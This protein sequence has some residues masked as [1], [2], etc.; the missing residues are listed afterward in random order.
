MYEFEFETEAMP[1]SQEFEFEYEGEELMRHV[2]RIPQHVSMARIGQLAARAALSA[3]PRFQ[4]LQNEYEF[5]FEDEFEGEF[6]FE[7]ELNPIRRVYP[8]ALME[9]MGHAAA[10]TESEAEAEAFVGALV[11]MAARLAAGAAPAVRRL[12]PHLVRAVANIVRTLRRNPATRALVRAVPTIIQRTIASLARMYA[13]RQQINVQIALRVLARH[14]ADL[15]GNQQRTAQV[16]RQS[17]NL[18]RQYHQR[19]GPTAANVPG[20]PTG[21]CRCRRRRPFR[22]NLV[23][24]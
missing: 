17:S 12:L 14:A 24:Q 11:P 4:G 20:G 7:E 8:D 3:T 19:V 10:A 15:L 18:D 22:C 9:H 21:H 16:I 13:R 5:E 6:E 23:C 2:R 1:G